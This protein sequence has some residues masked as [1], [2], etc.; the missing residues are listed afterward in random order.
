MPLL[1]LLPTAS[2]TAEPIVVTSPASL[3]SSEGFTANGIILDDGGGSCTR[4][5]FQV[6]TVPYPDREFYDDGFFIAGSFSEVVDNLMPGTTYFYRAYAIN[7]LGI[8]YGSWESITTALSTYSVTINGVDRTSDILNETIVVEDNL[9]DEQNTLTFSLI[10]RSGS[11]I[12]Q[13]DEE[14]VITLDGGDTLFSGYITTVN[15]NSVLET[16]AIKIDIQCTDQ[17]RLLDRNLVNKGYTNQTDKE[18]IE[19]II[20]TYCP[21]FGITTNNVI[22][23]VTIDQI[24]FNYVQPSQVFRRLCDLTGRNWFIDY[25]KDIHYF[26]LTTSSAPFNINSSNAQYFDLKISKDASQ[27]KNRVYVRGGTRLSDPTTHSQKGDA[28]KRQFLLPD[29]PHDVSVTVNGVSKTV[30][31]K[32]VNL[33]GF[34]YY[35]NFQEKYVEQDS[36]AVVLSSSDVLAVTYTYDIPILVAVEDG[37]SIIENGQ[38]EFAIFDKSIS[39]QQAARDRASAELTDYANNIIEGSFKTFTSGFQSGQFINIDLDSYGVNANYIITKVVAHAFGAGNYYYEISL[40]SAKTMGIIR[41]LIELLENNRNLIEVSDDEVVDNLLSVTDSLLSDSL[42]D[43]LT[44]DSAGPYATWC[45]DSLQAT[46]ITRARWDLFQ[47]G[48]D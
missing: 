45:T 33:S 41:F 34:D 37:A 32:N 47:W 11:G 48:Y 5:G 2:A 27:I 17:V 24:N 22:E 29:K 21:D 6:N 10:N 28:E 4:R 7:D 23:G 20:S 15:I 35:V 8:G 1:L 36:G 46:P 44:I 18:I 3:V 14:I 38:K 13:N 40:A 42:T 30:G 39:T 31:I 25:E 16:G 43:N 12:P 19:D 26:P 9:N